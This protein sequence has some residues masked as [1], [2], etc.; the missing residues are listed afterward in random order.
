V[1]PLRFMESAAAI[2]L[3]ICTCLSCFGV[4]W[5]LF[6]FLFFIF[7][8]SFLYC[9]ALLLLSLVILGILGG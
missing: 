5:N 8:L 4:E 2:Y 7:L 9:L 6:E 1:E 3:E